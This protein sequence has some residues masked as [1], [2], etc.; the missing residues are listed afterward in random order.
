MRALSAALLIALAGAVVA[1]GQ[2]VP[3]SPVSG[4][5]EA[6][7]DTLPLREL[8]GDPG[9]PDPVVRG[10]YLARIG[11]CVACHTEEESGEEGF[12]AG[13]KAI[14][15]PFG[16]FYGTNIT[17][18]PEHGIG[19]WS[20]DDLSRAL[21]EGQGPDGTHLY[22]S[23][24]Y[25]AFTGMTDEDVSDLHAFL[26]AVPPVD[27]ESRPHEISWIA[28]F[29]TG[30]A[31]WKSL[32]FDRWSFEPDP[33]RDEEWNRGAYLSRAVAHCAECH[34]PR[35]RT[36][37]IRE[38]LRYAGT[39][40]GPDGEVMPNITPHD[41]TGIGGWSE[42]H[43]IRYLEFGMTP[44]GDFAGGSMAEVISEGTSYLTNEDRR[45]LVRYILSLP[46]VEHAVD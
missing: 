6:P 32:N 12:L 16:T 5:T 11:N 20:E 13:G 29:R 38:E 3:P 7:S 26:Q 28:R 37:G 46:P 44:D 8:R 27:R 30:L 14:E 40:E 24:P 1:V 33:E 43:L 2:G 18:H 4:L 17:P 23:F 36:G 25:P 10:A 9:S 34:S 42:R 15:S 19:G 45:A 31:V 21:R 22:P 41:E 39:P 35:T